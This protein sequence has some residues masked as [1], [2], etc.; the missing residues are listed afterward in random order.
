[1]DSNAIKTILMAVKQVGD[2]ARMIN[3]NVDHVSMCS[4]GNGA[5]IT[6]WVDEEKSISAHMFDDGTFRIGDDYYHA[7]GTLDFRFEGTEKAC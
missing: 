6:A 3:P 2:I 1:M 5:D 7:D 4:I